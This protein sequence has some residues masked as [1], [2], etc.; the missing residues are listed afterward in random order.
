MT[1][2]VGTL[3]SK[4]ELLVGEA[5]DGGLAAAVA[6]EHVVVAARLYTLDPRDRHGKGVRLVP[7]LEVAGAEEVHGGVGALECKQSLR[8]EAMHWDTKHTGFRPAPGLSMI[9]WA[10]AAGH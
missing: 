10:E 4:H 7:G 3:H 2:G 6:E 5:E 8:K 9:A 1:V